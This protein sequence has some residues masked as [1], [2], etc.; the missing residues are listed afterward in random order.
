VV[1]GK[2]EEARAG[3]VTQLHPLI[4]STTPRT[5]L[6]KHNRSH[7]HRLIRT[8]RACFLSWYHFWRLFVPSQSST[9]CARWCKNSATVAWSLRMKL[10]V[11]N[12]GLDRA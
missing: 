1:R 12:R 4:V 5:E 8:R 2:E 7:T 3:S 9:N 11:F 10:R 6:Y